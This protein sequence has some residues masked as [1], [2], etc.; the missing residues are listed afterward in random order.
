MWV[1]LANYFGLVMDEEERRPLDAAVAAD[2]SPDDAPGCAEIERRG[3]CGYPCCSCPRSGVLA[4]VRNS[5]MTQEAIAICKLAVPM[6]STRLR[7]IQS[8]KLRAYAIYDSV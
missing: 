8:R 1:E 4:R 6:V 2:S 5:W 7:H 3:G